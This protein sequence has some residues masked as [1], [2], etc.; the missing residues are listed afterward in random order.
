MET[1]M[2]P[3]QPS[4][5]A[6]VR[7]TRQRF[8]PWACGALVGAAW[9]P[10]RAQAWPA[11]AV[12]IVVG[13]APGGGVDLMARALA[14]PLSDLLGQSIAIDN[15]AG[16]SGNLSAAEIIRSTPDG[17]NLLFGPMTQ[18]TVNPSLIKGSPNSARDLVPVGLIGR[19][20]LHL[21]AKKGLPAANVAELVKLARAKPGSISYGS[22]GV[23]TSPHLLAELFQKRAGVSLLH[24][25]YKGSGP[26]LQSILAGETDITFTTGVGYQHVRTGR[27]GMLAV[28][29]DRRAPEFPEVPTMIE[30]GYPDIVFDAWIGIW[31][32]VATPQAV[33]DRLTKALSDACAQPAVMK[34][35][36]DFNAEA[37]FVDSANFRR[38]LEKETETMS[39]LV[40]ERNISA[41]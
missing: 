23:G 2:T 3:E 25:P 17:Y 37:K 13:T 39:A 21:Y 28:A 14:Q 35:F 9:M 11:R 22:S 33:L 18:Q 6:E 24:V 27:L 30:A 41:E 10:A 7:I 4:A 1:D 31:A 38:M 40:R 20:Q 8:V 32:P 29:S 26:A 36:S 5:P 12:R 19:S 16:G 34:K 15:K